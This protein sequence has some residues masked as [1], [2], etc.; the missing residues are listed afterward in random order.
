MSDIANNLNFAS[1]IREHL[2][3]IKF[4]HTIFALP[5]AII[6]A[7]LARNGSSPSASEFAFIILAMIG[8]RTWAMSVNRAVDAHI[9]AQNPR[10]KNRSLPSGRLLSKQVWLAAALG[11]G[12]FTLSAAMLSKTAL[13][14]SPVILVILA[15]YSYT[16]RFTF[17][18]HYWLGL[19][20]GLAPLGAWVA[21]QNEIS[22]NIFLLSCA[23]CF[24]VSGFDIIYALQDQ[25]FD[26]S[27]NLHSIPAKFGTKISLYIARFSHALA[28]VLFFI[29]GNLFH[30]GIPYFLGVSVAVLLM[31]YEHWLVRKGDLK[32]INMAFFN[33]NGWIAVL[34]L[35]STCLSLFL[36]R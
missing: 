2:E 20:L 32:N 4:S 13:W 3:S 36:N 22:P 28:A 15:S 31:I 24:W 25:D 6:A 1:T 9:D 30:L 27:L 21:L 7:L 8:A 12:V 19:C 10:T 14:C 26:R 17:F 18:C 29:F 23:I 33:L 34:L 5:F 16:K 35:T 11:A